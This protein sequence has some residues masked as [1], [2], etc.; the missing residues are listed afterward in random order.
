MAEPCPWATAVLL[1]SGQVAFT[2]PSLHLHH[3]PHPPTPRAHHE[4]DPEVYFPLGQAPARA[5]VRCE[6]DRQTCPGAK[7]ESIE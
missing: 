2:G 3:P 1:A 5:G 4:G 7:V 6:Q